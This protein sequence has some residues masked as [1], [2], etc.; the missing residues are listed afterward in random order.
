MGN[1]IKREYVPCEIKVLEF[2]VERGFADSYFDAI[3]SAT[4]VY[5]W[6]MTANNGHYRNEGYEVWNGFDWGGDRMP[7]SMNNKINNN[8]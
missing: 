1:Q 3:Q 7:Q 5:N 8:R 2:E 4:N 6:K